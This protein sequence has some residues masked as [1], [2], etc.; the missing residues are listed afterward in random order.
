MS[1]KGKLRT[2]KDR[3][4]E[5]LLEAEKIS[6]VKAGSLS[7][8]EYVRITV[9]NKVKGRLNK[10]ELNFIGGYASMRKQLIDEGKV[11][12]TIQVPKILVLDIETFPMEAYVWGLFDQNIG[13]NQIKKDWSIMSWSARWL[14]QPEDTVM[15]MDVRGQRNLRDDK[16][17][18]KP[19]LK[20]MDEADIVCGQNSKSFDVKKINA[21]AKINGYK[22]PSSFR[23]YDTKI[24]A[25]RYFSFTSN[26]LEY[27]THKLC[28]DSK[29]LSH[30]NFPGFSLWSACLEDNLEAWEECEAYNKADVNSTAELLLQLLPWDN[31]INW[32]VYRDNLTFHACTC[33][34]TEFKKNGFRTTNTGKFQRFVCKQCG[35]ES[36]S[37]ENL[38]STNFRK[39]LRKKC[40]R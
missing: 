24:M 30:A 22:P 27:L 39:K 17:I 35:K 34:S 3:F 38:K 40:D 23:Q 10:E 31:T 18:L 37:K 11:D 19:L 9:D 32:E 12:V 21:R 1:K 7:R 4:E 8:D 15:Y 14:D 6:G 5:T 25:K 20:L 36:S 29:K 13:L 33:G 16:K 26:K 2:L 28:T